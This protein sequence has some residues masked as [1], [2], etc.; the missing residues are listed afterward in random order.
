MSGITNSIVYLR[1]Y[2]G[3]KYKYLLKNEE[4]NM[5][6]LRIKDSDMPTFYLMDKTDEYYI[7]E[8]EDYSSRGLVWY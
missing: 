6:M 3:K 2:F 5:D 7:F 4:L 8:A 1:L